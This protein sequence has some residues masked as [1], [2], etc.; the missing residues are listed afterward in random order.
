MS[1]ALPCSMGQVRLPQSRRVAFG[2][3]SD[4]IA[5]AAKKC[6]GAA[7]A[8]AAIGTAIPVVGTAIGAGGGCAA[9]VL[10]DILTSQGVDEAQAQ[11][12]IAQQRA[13]IEQA[14]KEE[15]AKAKA[16]RQKEA[17]FL[18]GGAAVGVVLLLALVKR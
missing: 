17:L 18:I 9:A 1:S 13:A 7:A 3:I 2:A 8:G 12:I 5:S 15:L 6:A 4:S 14:Y 10:F 11:A 16:A